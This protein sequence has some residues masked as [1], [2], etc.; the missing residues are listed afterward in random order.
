MDKQDQVNHLVSLMTL[1]E[2]SSLLSGADKWHTKAIPRVGLA[3][4]TVSD[5]PHGLRKEVRDPERGLH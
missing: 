3:T 4:V 1:A 5:G 2:K